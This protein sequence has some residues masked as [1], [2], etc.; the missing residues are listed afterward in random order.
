MKEAIL[1]LNLKKEWFDLIA[2]GQKKEEYRE[3]KPFWNKR[4]GSSLPLIKIKGICYLPTDVLICFS[5]GYAR[6]RR[7]MFV[8]CKGLE[9]K[10]GI[11][12]WGAIDGVE[13]YTLLLGDIIAQNFV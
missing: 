1:H 2:S 12:E 3:I 11:K 13:Y 6:D 8:E 10:E 4:F 9:T 5:N 7:Q